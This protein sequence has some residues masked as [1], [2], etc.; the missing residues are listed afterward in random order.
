MLFFLFS[1]DPENILF[2]KSTTAGPHLK[3]KIKKNSKWDGKRFL[4]SFYLTPHHF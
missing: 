4:C 2:E 1:G 3:D